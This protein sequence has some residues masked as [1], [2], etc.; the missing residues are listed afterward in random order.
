MPRKIVLNGYTY[1]K[2]EDS[3][4][5]TPE[6]VKLFEERTAKHIKLVQ[7][8]AKI[9]FDKFPKL[10]DLPKEAENH[11]KSKYSPEERDGYIRTTWSYKT[12]GKPASRDITGPSWAHHKK[13]ND[14]HPDHW[15]VLRPKF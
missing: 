4:K 3:M 15:E 8:Y 2:A 1:L 10:K 13:V 11:D 9:L 5:I 14:H 12:T 6:M 7:K